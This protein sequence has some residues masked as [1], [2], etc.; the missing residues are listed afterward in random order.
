MSP[1]GVYAPYMV[2]KYQL[3][4]IKPRLLEMDIYSQKDYAPVEVSLSCR[5]SSR[6]PPM[7]QN[8]YDDRNGYGQ[9]MFGGKSL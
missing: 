7:Y 8:D 2:I 3:L 6:G 5:F 9:V 4:V 1:I